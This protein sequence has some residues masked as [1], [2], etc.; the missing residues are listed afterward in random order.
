MQ[1]PPR[2]SLI[3]IF[4]GQIDGKLSAF[5]NEVV[6]V[7]LRPNADG[8]HAGL[9]ADGARPAAVSYTHLDVYKRQ[10]YP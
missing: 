10:H 5:L 1:A 3:H 2:L 7:A 8:H 4:G 6:A 9:G